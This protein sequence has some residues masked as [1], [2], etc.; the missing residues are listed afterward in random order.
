MG[1]AGLL[2]GSGKQEGRP[3]HFPMAIL[4]QSEPATCRHCGSPYRRPAWGRDYLCPACARPLTLGEGSTRRPVPL[5]PLIY[6]GVAL[7]LGAGLF[8]VTADRLA[9]NRRMARGAPE[10]SEPVRLP[11][12]FAERLQDKL[13][14]FETDLRAQPDQSYLLIRAGETALSLALLHRSTHPAEASRWRRRAEDYLRRAKEVQYERPE[15]DLERRIRG[16]AQLQWGSELTSRPA[17]QWSGR[18]VTSSVRVPDSM[19]PGAPRNSPGGY[20]PGSYPGFSA[21]PG[22]YS[23]PRYPG[24]SYPPGSSIPG[25]F[26]ATGYLGAVNAEDPPR[27]VPPPTQSSAAAYPGGA[28]SWSGSPTAARPGRR[29]PAGDTAGEGPLGLARKELKAAPDD[30][31]AVWRLANLIE[32]GARLPPRR[33][34]VHL[35]PTERQRAQSAEAI[36]LYLRAAEL[37][38][39]RSERATCYHDVARIYGQLNQEQREYEYLRKA[40]GEAPSTPAFWESL[41]D[42]CIRLG[43]MQESQRAASEARRWSL[44][45]AVLY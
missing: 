32:T 3:S 43:R 29:S 2:P 8:R 26:R 31:V 27:P 45:T 18:R 10:V 41:R 9:Q 24:P 11:A 25:T 23:G 42:V 15:R 21:P 38:R 14:F 16:F 17:E 33:R 30:P 34:S 35:P 12:N 7:A 20:P 44:P 28:T 1:A 13:R 4:E 40:I 22:N 6:A 36:R 5:R 19:T 39:L 37:T